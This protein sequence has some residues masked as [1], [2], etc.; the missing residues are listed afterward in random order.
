MIQGKIPAPTGTSNSGSGVVVIL[1]LMVAAGAFLVF[2][3]GM[4]FL[5]QILG[6]SKSQPTP[7]TT[8]KDS[9]PSDNTK[10]KSLEELK[11]ILLEEY[12]DDLWSDPAS[13]KSIAE[14]AKRNNLSNREQLRYDALWLIE[15]KYNNFEIG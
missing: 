9:K 6:D 12:M 7:G 1:I 14:K 10:G 15:E 4:K 3:N 2:G 11:V 13:R 5:Q 8:P